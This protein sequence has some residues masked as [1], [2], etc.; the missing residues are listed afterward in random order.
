MLVHAR[1]RSELNYDK[2][3]GC[4]FDAS[5]SFAL[6]L[7]QKGQQ[8]VLIRWRVLHDLKF[9]DHWAI[10]LNEN[11]SVDLTSIQFDTAGEVL[12]KIESYPQ[13]FVSRMEYPVEIFSTIKTRDS[14]SHRLSMSV[15]WTVHT[16]T[17]GYD[18]RRTFLQGRF[19]LIPGLLG[20]TSR[21]YYK[22]LVNGLSQWA[23]GR[24]VVLSRRMSEQKNDGVAVQ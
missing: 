24:Y 19:R 4:C 7:S 14:Q 18:L 15:M 6:E 16:A 17:F 3:C 10:K 9:A 5:L 13:N 12:Q 8:L 2:A 11:F 1:K 22:I 21:G 23:N 20:R